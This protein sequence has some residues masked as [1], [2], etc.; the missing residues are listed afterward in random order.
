MNT[1]IL[2]AW[3]AAEGE[4]YRDDNGQI[5]THHWLWPEKA[6]LI[7]GSIASLLIFGLLYKFAGPAIKKAFTGRTER[8]QGELDAAEAEAA[9]A[10]AEAATIRAAK[11]DI[12]AERA[13]L[14]AEADEQA[15]AL[16]RDGLSPP[17]A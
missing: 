8:I 10:D 7:Y 12:D 11:G 4:P 2:A 16:L 1:W 15:E 5:V 9:A 17:R 6:E 13:R 3:V 14:F